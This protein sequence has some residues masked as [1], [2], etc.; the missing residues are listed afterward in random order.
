MQAKRDLDTH[1]GKYLSRHGPW[2][3]TTAK[4]YTGSQLAHGWPRCPLA[5]SVAESRQ[6]CDAT[7]EPGL[8]SFIDSC[9]PAG[10]LINLASAQNHHQDVPSVILNEA[11][12]GLVRC[13]EESVETT[14]VL[15]EE[16]VA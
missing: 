14:S 16:S 3:D 7:D 9:Q 5:L 15:R 6:A 1:I 13:H 2:E 12:C 8:L 4:N 10:F 11:F